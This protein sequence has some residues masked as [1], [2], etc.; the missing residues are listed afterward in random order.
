MET[1]SYVRTDDPAEAVKQVTGN[2][3][4]EFLGASTKAAARVR[5]PRGRRK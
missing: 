5:A 4:A 2:A 3:R 1:F